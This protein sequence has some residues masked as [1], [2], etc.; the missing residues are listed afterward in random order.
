MNKPWEKQALRWLSPVLPRVLSWTQLHSCSPEQV[1]WVLFSLCKG[2]AA[3]TLGSSARGQGKILL[4]NSSACVVWV[5][6]MHPSISVT[7]MVSYNLTQFWH[8]SPSDPVRRPRW[9]KDS[10]LQDSPS[11][12]PDTSHKSR[13]HLCFRVTGY[14]LE[15]QRTH[16]LRLISLLE[17]LTELRN[18]FYWLCNQCVLKG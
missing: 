10:V 7:S 2:E 13:C 1:G 12:T 5:F 9:R 4:T 14:R 16:C 8:Y 11:P 15:I 6:P 17:W 18:T 3:G